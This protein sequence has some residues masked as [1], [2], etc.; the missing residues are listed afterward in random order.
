M[1]GREH[2]NSQRILPVGTQ[3]SEKRRWRQEAEV[4]CTPSGHE[5]D[6]EMKLVNMQDK[7]AQ[8]PLFPCAGFNDVI[9]F[10]NK[11]LNFFIFQKVKKR[12]QTYHGFNDNS[13]VS[14]SISQGYI[15]STMFQMS[16][17]LQV[18]PPRLGELCVMGYREEKKQE[19]NQQTTCAAKGKRIS[20]VQQSKRCVLK[21]DLV[22]G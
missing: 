11:F 2:R 6:E 17:S 10:I 3:Q 7:E 22:N 9:R 21:L 18:G 16:N 19:L 1:L 15:T 8:L 12:K 5:S 13:E 14:L 20:R 4:W